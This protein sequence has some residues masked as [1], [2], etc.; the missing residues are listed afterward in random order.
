MIHTEPDDFERKRYYQTL[1]LECLKLA[2]FY[3]DDVDLARD[4]IEDAKK[5]FRSITEDRW[6]SEPVV[7]TPSD[8]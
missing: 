8:A 4:A 3:Q 7:E 2:Q 1:K 6:G 5:I